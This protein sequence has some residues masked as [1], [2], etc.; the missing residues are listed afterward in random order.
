MQVNLI[1]KYYSP[2]GG[3][4]ESTV[5]CSGDCK[6]SQ[7]LMCITYCSRCLINSKRKKVLKR[8]RLAFVSFDKGS[9]QICFL[10]DQ[11]N[12]EIKR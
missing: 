5:L 2:L 12:L 8:K 7:V 4:L 11:L 6:E 3:Y 10:D 9:Q 1:S